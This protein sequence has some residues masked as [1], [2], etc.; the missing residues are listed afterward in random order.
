MSRPGLLRLGLAPGR[1]HDVSTAA[2]ALLQSNSDDLV[3]NHH[4]IDLAL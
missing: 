4:R 1:L 3:G 2:Q